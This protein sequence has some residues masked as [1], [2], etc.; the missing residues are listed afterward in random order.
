MRSMIE[1]K[2][3]DSRLGDW[4]TDG[5]DANGVKITLPEEGL[6]PEFKAANS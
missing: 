2:I 4:Y 5:T 3:D 1:Q 6:I